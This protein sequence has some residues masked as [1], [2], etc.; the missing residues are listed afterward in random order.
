MSRIQKSFWFVFLLVFV[1][2]GFLFA[3]N[4]YALVIGNGRYQSRDISPL[5]NPA[6]DATDMAAVLK[7]LGYNVTL[8]TNAGLRDMLDALRDFSLDLRRSSENEGFFWFAGHGLSV[9]NIHYMLPVDVDPVNDNIIA[10]GSVSVDDLMEEIGNARNKTNLIVIDACRNTLLPGGSRNVGSRGLAVLAADDYRVS[11]NKIVY[12]TMAGRTAAD[13]VPGSRNSPFAQAF[14]SNIKNPESFDDLFLDIAN[15][16]MRLT[17]GDQQPYSMGTFAVKSYTINP[18]PPAA[19]APA[20]APVAAY[21][22]PVAPLPAPESPSVTPKPP[23]EPRPPKEGVVNEAQL[24]SAGASIGTSF[25]DPWIVGTLRG[26][27]APIN[28]AFLELGVDIGTV[29]AVSEVN[30][31]YLICPFAHV[32]YFRPLNEIAGLYAG[33][34]GGYL[35][36]EYFFEGLDDSEGRS[37]FVAD[38]VVGVNLFS[39]LDVSYTFRTS[40][41]RATNKLSVGY[42]YRF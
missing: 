15:E 38:V 3:Q 9:R 36:A 5:A 16:T 42:S 13:G 26:T 30:G 17:R 8:R 22:A 27:I 41:S 32:A 19:A 37:F 2:G 4:R 35:R 39:R 23:K 34:G 12:S 1:G 6:N 31:S 7:E 24:W 40:F 11:G 33:A 29:S 28:N 10:R 21:Q 25:A 18:L 20:A 14:I